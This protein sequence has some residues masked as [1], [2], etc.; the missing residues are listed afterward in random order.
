VGVDE[1]GMLLPP[2]AVR[3]AALRNAATKMLVEGRIGS[4]TS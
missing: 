3:I 1:D 4:E 2:H